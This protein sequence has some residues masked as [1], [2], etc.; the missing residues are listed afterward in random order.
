MELFVQKG[1][2]QKF[3]TNKP[4]VMQKKLLLNRPGFLR[5]RYKV[6]LIMQFVTLFLVV[7]CMQLSANVHSQKVTLSF[8]N[9]NLEKALSLIEKNTPYRFVYNDDYIRFPHRVSVSATE[10]PIEEVLGNLLHNTQL[11][12]RML[13]SKLIVIAP[14]GKEYLDISV[15]G[16]VVN[17]LNEPLAGVTVQLKNSGIS[18]TTDA[19]GRFQITVPENGVLVFTY[20]GHLEQEVAVTGASPLNITLQAQENSMDEVVVLGYGSERK[21]NVTGAVDQISGKK[22]AERP[23]SN[24]FQGLQGLSPGLNITY[25]S[26]FPGGKPNLNVRGVATLTA[27]G[28]E[29]LIV[30]D[31]IQANSNDI[32][33]LNPQDIASMSVLR[34]AASAA[35][36]GARAAFGVIL[37]TTKQG[38]TGGKPRISY[39]NYFALSKPTVV[40]TT[41]TD[42]YIFARVLETST[43]NTPWD[44][45]N[46]SDEYYQWAKERSN[47]PSV[48]DVRVNQASNQWMYMGNTDFVK[49]FLNDAS[50]SQN[51][52]LSFSGGSE[53]SKGMPFTYLLSADWTKEAGLNKI[54]KDKWQRHGLR[55]KMTLTP[56]KWFRVE[57]NLNIYQT[58][59]TSPTRGIDGVYYLMPTEVAKNPDGSW[60]NT[61][62]G[63]HG[64]RMEFG[65]QR[66]TR[67]LGFQN[68]VRGIASF[69][70]NDLQI[71][72]SG[73]F[74]RDIERRNAV[75][76]QYPIGVGPGDVRLR[77]ETSVGMNNF[78]TRNDVFDLFATYNKTL[79]GDHAIKLL[80]GYNQ[81]VYEMENESFTRAGLISSSLPYLSLATG[82]PTLS[83]TYG[84]Y[85]LRS[86]FGRVNYTYRGKYIL[87]ANVRRDG[88]SR[89]PSVRRWGG[90]PSV[91]AAWIVS[92][93][94]FFQ[95]V[96]NTVSSLKFRVS[97]GDL[98]NQQVGDF[99]YIQ[100]LPITPAT[101]YIIGGA[102]PIVIQG[103]PLLRVDPDTYTWEKIRTLNL[104]TDIGLA[105]D[106]IQIGFD[107]FVRNT[108]GMLAPSHALPAVMG[109]LAPLQNAADLSTKGFE[110]TVGY[111]DHF[112]VGNKPFSV[113]AR[114]LLSDSRSTVTR[115]SNPQQLLHTPDTKNYRVGEEIGEIWG[116]VND[117][118]F[119]TS[120]EI[121]ALN[122]SAIVPWGALSVV[123]GW[124]RYVDL[125]KDNRIEL[126]TTAMDPRDLKIIG[127]SMPRYRVGFNL[128]LAWQNFDFTLFLQGV[129][130]QDYYP[131]NYLFWGPLQQPYAGVYPWNLDFYR[132]T[133]ETGAARDRHSDS[134]IAAG[135]ADA[136]TD[137]FY[138]VLQSWLADANDRRGLDIPQTQYLLSA[139]YLRVKNITIGYTLPASFTRKFK[140][141]RLRVFF[142]GENVFEF[143]DI[144]KFVDPEIASQGYDLSV[145]Q[146][147][148]TVYP[149]SRKYSFGFNFDL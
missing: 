77:G 17:A 63:E 86:L 136:N 88:S 84:S 106:R 66:Y 105:N 149:F 114:V 37:I 65:G 82:N 79:A 62:A 32:F 130:K 56:M 95:T 40:P 113:G 108:I 87:E 90:F 64:S 98:G 15:S 8:T 83:T 43:D 33:R 127:N 19:E 2:K 58:G 22:L 27:G 76:Q 143:S 112:M 116:L 78:T 109:A 115:Y 107:Y 1:F 39:N 71:I 12:F 131:R 69:L 45:V 28:A 128:D 46:Y 140:V 55:A 103:A 73:S 14:K 20:I 123:P 129:L 144:K 142:S 81:E 26:G 7:F 85:A 5:R 60:A 117:G 25:G 120:E 139:A 48:E 148:G 11:G 10:A 68:I 47:N 124:M 13:S 138:P 147:N 21:I 67:I 6:L 137:S 41:V 23:I 80:A 4:K 99:G 35:I 38:S 75:N 61:P 101:S 96:R 133:A 3:I 104:G 121:A 134:Y 97:Y 119:A 18:T 74:K 146:G 125:N 70:D 34:D 72:A 51:H 91:S 135:L 100:T 9:A 44:Y 16:R 53:G 93:E 36:Y 132:A 110:L 122:V 59:V 102:R 31:G 145:S 94:N 52:S 57:N 126:G 118:F 24:L 30:I 50:P 54:V 89:F 49:Y 92:E 42:P 141:D 111:R 29:P